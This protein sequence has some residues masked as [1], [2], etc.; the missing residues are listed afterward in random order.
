MKAPDPDADRIAA[1]IY[2]IAVPDWPG[3]IGF[4]AGNYV[5]RK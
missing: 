1:E 3:E 4:Y 5:C 2:D